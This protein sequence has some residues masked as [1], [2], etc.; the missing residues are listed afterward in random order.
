MIRLHRAEEIM[1]T[2]K[3]LRLET[4]KFE[5]KC[6]AFIKSVSENKSLVEHSLYTV[7]QDLAELRKLTQGYILPADVDEDGLND[8]IQKCFAVVMFGGFQGNIKLH[9]LQ[10][11]ADAD[12]NMT[13]AS[14]KEDVLGRRLLEVLLAQAKVL[15]QNITASS[16]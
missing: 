14:E 9:A 12:V 3:H 11:A 1:D 15:M 16:R 13:D 2:I 10:H 6:S 8:V 5:G 7:L 4:E